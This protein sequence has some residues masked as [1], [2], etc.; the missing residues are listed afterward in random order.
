M[1]DITDISDVKLGDTVI[2]IGKDGN[3]YISVADMASL[4]ENKQ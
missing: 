4:A 1:V 3:N 2:L